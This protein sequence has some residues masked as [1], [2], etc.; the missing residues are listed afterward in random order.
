MPCGQNFLGLVR[1]HD[2]SNCHRLR[3]CLLANPLRVWYLEPRPPCD[4]RHKWLTFVVATKPRR[5]KHAT[6]R[7]ADDGEVL[8][9]FTELVGDIKRYGE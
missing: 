6:G 5:S 7:H 4:A 8:K 9:L 1:I 3:I 2:D